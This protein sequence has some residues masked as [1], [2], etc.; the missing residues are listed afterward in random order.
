M[1]FA[2]PTHIV[3]SVVTAAGLTD[4]S[5]WIP[6]N[7][8][9]LATQ[10]KDV[11]AIGDCAGARNSKGQ[12]LPRAGGLAEEE[13]KVVASNLIRELAGDPVRGEFQGKGVCFIETEENKATALQANF[14]A[15]PVPTWESKPSSAEGW[16]QKVQFLEDRMKAWFS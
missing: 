6:V 8:G 10:F 7:S 13:G 14:Y 9:T 3:P 11:Y 4:K 5:G 16:T 2:V 12:L 15:E 1:L